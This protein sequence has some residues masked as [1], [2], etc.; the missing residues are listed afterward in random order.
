MIID[1]IE[2]FPEKYFILKFHKRCSEFPVF[3]RVFS[4][5]FPTYGDPL[6]SLAFPS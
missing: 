1:M 6:E 2:Y 3:Q 5:V 4:L